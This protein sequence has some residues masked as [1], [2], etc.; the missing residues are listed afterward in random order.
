MS[1]ISV[2]ILAPDFCSKFICSRLCLELRAVMT[3][4]FIQGLSFF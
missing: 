1:F 3:L 4:F 2:D